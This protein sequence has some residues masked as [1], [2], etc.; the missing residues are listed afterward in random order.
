VADEEQHEVVIVGGGP[1]GVSCALECYDIQL[2]TVLLEANAT[3]G[4]QLGEIPH[5][6]HNVV[7]EGFQRG[8]GLRQSL[9]R[10][11]EILGDRVRL[12]HA[13]SSVDFDHLSVEAS[14]IRFHAKALVIASGV[15]R[16]RLSKAIDGAWG[17]DV[18]YQVE[19]QPGR[20]AGRPV[21]VIGGGDSATLDALE[22]ARAGSPVTLIHRSEQLTA[23]RDIIDDVRNEPRIADLAGWELDAVE[24]KD[25]LEAIVVVRPETDERQRLAVSGLVV[26]ISYE[27][28]TGIF[29]GQLDLDRHGAV[30]VDDELRTSRRGVFA[31]GDVTAGAYPRIA[32]ATGQGLLAAR[33][34]LRYLADRS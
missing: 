7:F 29:S 6:V 9:E 14:G 24:G 2:D 30:V 31:A 22:L 26:K 20:F 3:L 32:T 17:G 16:R 1:A 18:T 34:V 15:T 33:S 4:G 11:A 27:P 25:H 23:R 12:A 5:V 28:A 8:Q 10:S 13:V 19:R 21:A